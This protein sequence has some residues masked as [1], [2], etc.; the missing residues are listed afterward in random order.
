MISRAMRKIGLCTPSMVRHECA[1]AFTIGRDIGAEE[2]NSAV[3]SE[4]ILRGGATE[5]VATLN[6]ND[7]K[8]ILEYTSPQQ[9]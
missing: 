3:W 9:A 2:N 4:I 1:K 5:V 6:K 8:K 7:D